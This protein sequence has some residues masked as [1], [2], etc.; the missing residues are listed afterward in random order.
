MKCQQCGKTNPDAARFCGYCGCVFES[1]PEPQAE[2]FPVTDDSSYGETQA[3]QTEK[4]AQ[5]PRFAPAPKAWGDDEVPAVRIS[6]LPHIIVSVLAAIMAALQF[7]L[8]TADWVSYRY[9]ALGRDMGHGTLRLY[10]L[11]KKFFMDKNIVAFLTGLDD[12]LGISTLV[13]KKVNLKFDQG[14][15]AALVLAVVLAISLLLY[16][17][18]I[19]M[20]V[21]RRRAAVPLGII[22][23]ALN[24][25]GCFSVLVAVD[26]LNSVAEQVV[27]L[28][29]SSMK[30]SVCTAPY[31]CI[32]LSAAVIVFC[33]VMAALRSR[34]GKR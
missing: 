21:C 22:A 1:E 5:R 29:M 30:F 8:V 6:K 3:Y 34:E 26:M 23:A 10:E 14:R 16:F 31:L 2:P 9:E 17:V 25:A 33:G 28:K 7:F 12:D 15:I 19:V 20:A 11:C 24:I 4:A 32:A 13:P 18:F 27:F